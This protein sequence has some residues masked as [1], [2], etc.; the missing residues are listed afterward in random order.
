MC[1]YSVL[2]GNEGLKTARF[3]TIIQKLL[4]CRCGDWLYSVT[5]DVKTCKGSVP[6]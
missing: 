6:E 5:E 3:V 4:G 1:V 2:M